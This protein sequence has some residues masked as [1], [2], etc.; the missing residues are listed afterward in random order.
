MDYKYLNCDFQP[1]QLYTSMDSRKC[2]FTNT[3]TN[4]NK[5]SRMD[6]GYKIY[7]PKYPGSHI[8]TAQ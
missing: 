1:C 3:N 6:K 8:Y 4:T 7:T 5:P 2:E